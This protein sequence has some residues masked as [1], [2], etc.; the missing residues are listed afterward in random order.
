MSTSLLLLLL[1]TPLAPEV[2][3]PAPNASQRRVALP[4]PVARAPGGGILAATTDDWIPIDS[5]PFTITQP[6]GYYLAKS[7]T[8][9][10]GSAGI[11][12]ESDDVVI[13]L[14]GYVVK[15]VAGSLDGIFA[16]FGLDRI[17]VRN[18]TIQDWGQDG[19]DLSSARQCSVE[20]VRAR[21][22]GGGGVRLGQDAR[23][24]DCRA[25]ENQGVGF[26]THFAAL[27]E[28]CEA[29]DNRD[30]GFSLFERGRI[31]GCLAIGNAADGI[32]GNQVLIEACVAD[33]NGGHG[34]HAVSMS[35]VTRCNAHRSVGDGIR[36]GPNS[37]VVDNHCSQNGFNA[38][39]GA[40]VRATSGSRIEGNHVELNDRGIELSSGQSLVVRNSAF[41]NGTNYVVP[42]GAT[43][44]P[45]VTVGTVGTSTNPHA[46]YSL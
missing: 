30:A 18:G 21:T 23:I 35:Q 41:A 6:G 5:L 15:G 27:V 44:G 10:A 40:G 8:G 24:V 46:N 2:V 39:S 26:S 11:V 32:K 19:I 38:G 17:D 34:I 4:A 29:L 31:V 33:S 36:A 25:I 42:A 28:R 12:V 22:N 1:A 43:A 20:N 7:L 13:D 3:S 37:V 9:V 45:I 16:S 14:N